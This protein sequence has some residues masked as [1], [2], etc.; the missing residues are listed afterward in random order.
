VMWVT[1]YHAC[2]AMCATC[3]HQMLS[4]TSY[5]L[6]PHSRHT[7]YVHATMVLICIRAIC[8]VVEHAFAVTIVPSASAHKLVLPCGMVIN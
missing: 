8:N 3:I 2:L 4:L 5:A 1:S 7:G 6:L